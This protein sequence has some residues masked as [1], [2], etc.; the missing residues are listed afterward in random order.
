MT[1]GKV[2]SPEEDK[3]L[4]RMW[5]EGRNGSEIAKAV[6][7]TRSAVMG[8]IH[9]NGLTRGTGTIVVKQ[10]P[11][12]RPKETEELW[13]MPSVDRPAHTGPRHWTTRTLFECQFPVSGN[14]ADVFSCCKPTRTPYSYCAAHQKLMFVKSTGP[15]GKQKAK[16]HWRNAGPADGG[17]E[18][19]GAG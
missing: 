11:K 3:T 1:S 18:T 6:G 8:Y 7:R 4:R 9:R 19:L 13:T 17:A 15:Q 2:W 10:A 12:P 14:G 5:A 16:A